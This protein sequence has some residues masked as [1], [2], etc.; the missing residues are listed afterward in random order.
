[1]DKP[2]VAVFG[3]G[4]SAAYINAACKVRQITPD[5]YTVKKIG[6]PGGAFW[7]RLSPFKVL[8]TEKIHMLSVGTSEGYMVKQW[9]E[10][11][12]KMNSSFPHKPRVEYGYNP[13]HVWDS[14]W[15]GANIIYTEPITD[16]LAETK[17]SEY[18]IV[19]MTFP[20]EDSMNEQ[21]EFLV[22]T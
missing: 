21:S 6:G 4:P 2:R 15:E 10:N 17:A 22:S 14:L 5:I 9:G 3:A 13:V 19:F 7:L 1:M 18:D 16:K 20:T 11:H 12:S 8:P